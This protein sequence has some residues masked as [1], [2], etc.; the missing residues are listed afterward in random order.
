MSAK[1]IQKRQGEAQIGYFS[2]SD[3]F[4]RLNES[5][6]IR[7]VI[8]ELELQPHANRRWELVDQALPEEWVIRRSNPSRAAVD[9]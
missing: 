2:L 1:I 9:A 3:N 4:T 5:G 7:P 6:E 8:L